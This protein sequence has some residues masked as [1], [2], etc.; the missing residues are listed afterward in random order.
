MTEP[1]SS[2]EDLVAGLDLGHMNPPDIVAFFAGLPRRVAASLVQDDEPD[3]EPATD[4]DD[5]PPLPVDEMNAIADAL[6]RLI[7]RTKSV[8]FSLDPGVTVKGVDLSVLATLPPE[9]ESAMR[10]IE[11]GATEVARRLS[12]LSSAAWRANTDLLADA[13]SAVADAVGP[14]RAVERSAEDRRTGD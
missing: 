4:E 10:R 12:G 8:G 3:D 6:Q 9:V 5:A 7:D 14:L 2:Q 1:D 11:A 13:R